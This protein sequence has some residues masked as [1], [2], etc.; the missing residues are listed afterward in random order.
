MSTETDFMEKSQLVIWRGLTIILVVALAVNAVQAMMG[1]ANFA[2]WHL[3][4]L[5]ITWMMGDCGSYIRRLAA[6]ARLLRMRW[7]GSSARSS[8]RMRG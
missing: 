4:T 5:A 1:K 8:I 2:Y 6:G 7:R 3:P